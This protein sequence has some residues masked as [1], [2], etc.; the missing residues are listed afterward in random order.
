MCSSQHKISIGKI[1]SALYIYQQMFVCV[2]EDRYRYLNQDIVM[3]DRTAW[4]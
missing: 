1:Y 2:P 4:F 3:N